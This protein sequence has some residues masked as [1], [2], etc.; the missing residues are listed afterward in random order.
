[1]HKLGMADKLHI[2]RKEGSTAILHK[3][4]VI[5][6]LKVDK[7]HFLNLDFPQD[8][9]KC[10]LSDVLRGIHCLF[11]PRHVILV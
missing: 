9:I 5:F 6:T 3:I 10:R 4:E 2:D 8:L 1:M 7:T 11:M